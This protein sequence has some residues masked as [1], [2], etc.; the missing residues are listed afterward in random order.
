MVD[1]LLDEL[2]R[3]VSYVLGEDVHYRLLAPDWSRWVDHRC[4]AVSIHTD[5]DALFEMWVLAYHH[6]S[7]LADGASVESNVVAD[8][9]DLHAV[10]YRAGFLSW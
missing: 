10:R 7:A 1:G 5:N 4:S 2:P 9:C 3:L 8:I 6:L